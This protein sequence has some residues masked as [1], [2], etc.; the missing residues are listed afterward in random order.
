MHV[1][2]F[3]RSFYPETAATS[4]FLTELCEALVNEYGCRVS[5]VAGV[6][7]L[8]SDAEN[9]QRYG[10]ILN[11]ENYS[12]IE[13]VRAQGT[14]LPKTQFIGRFSN[15]ISYFL[16]ACYAGL[17]LDRPDVIV[18]LTDPPIIGL[19]GYLAARRFRA[20][21]I[22]YYQDIFPE[23]GRLLEDFHSQIVDRSL[24]QVNRFLARSA[25][26][27]IALGETMKQKLIEEKGADRGRTVV[28][29]LWAD[30]SDITPGPKLNRFSEANRLAGKFVVMHSGNI[31]LSQGLEVLLGA[32][33]RL[34]HLEELEIVFV[35]DGVKKAALMEEARLSGL[36][37]VRFLPF[38]PK[39]NL[40]ESFAAADLF[41][42][43]LKRGLA[44]VIVPSK[45][46]GILAAGRPYVAAVEQDCEIAAIT[47]ENDCGLVSE[48]ENAD[49]LAEK[50]LL[51]YRDRALGKRLG[52][53]ARKAALHFD[54][55]A[56]VGAYYELLCE[57]AESRD[58]KN[59]GQRSDVRRQ[60]TGIGNESEDRKQKSNG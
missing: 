46:Y 44:G 59:R 41:V 8:S 23:A 34:R 3:N 49:D 45:L 27:V 40:R 2:F 21:L 47:K 9:R 12:G 36:D 29:P 20:P 13:I 4:Q 35:G 51:L 28:L 43:S 58:C 19:A 60:Q 16:S 7:L 17:R 11:H 57:V 10:T 22:M 32:A 15:Y 55:K 38:Q 6:P 53:N 14:R 42:V 31:G 30:C 50:I 52:E 24:D 5:V 1:V 54:R 25:N 33:K 48:P 37:N 39:E 26:R 18:A 56:M